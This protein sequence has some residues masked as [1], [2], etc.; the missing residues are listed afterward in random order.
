VKPAKTS[1]EL[2]A[3]AVAHQRA[4]RAREAESAYRQLISRNPQHQQAL[5][6]LSVLFLQSGR[7]EEASRYLERLV[8]MA[9][10]QPVLLTNLGEA[11]RR[12]GELELAAT[13]FERILE[14]DP[15]FPEARQNLGITLMDAGR[16]NEALPHLE[17]AVALRPDSALFHVSLAW[18][19]GKLERPDESLEHA[20]HA[21]ELEPEHASGHLHLAN[22]Q[23]D[24]GDRAGAIASYRRAVEL[25]PSD[26]RAHSNLILVALADPAW[27]SA[28][29]HAE[30][31]AWAKLHAEPLRVRIE[32]HTNDRRAD[33]RLRVGYVSPDFRAHPVRQFLM[34]LLRHHEPSAVEVFLYSSVERPDFSTEE[35]RTL[36][37][38]RFR[39]ISRTDDLA[40][41]ALV[42]RDRIDV[43]L[44]LAVHGAGHRLRVFAM[45]PAPVQM[46]WLGYNGTTGLDTVDYRI[47]DPY[48]DPPGTDPSDFS[49]AP[50]V[51]PE[52]YWCYDALE[53]D[54]PVAPL[55]ALTDGH[56]TFGC[57]NSYRKV[58]PG[59]LALWSRVLAEAPGSR[60]ALLVADHPR[61]RKELES[62]G[63]DPSRVDFGGRS[64]RREY[65]E[66]HHHVD[67]ALDTFP[68]CGGTTS[69]DAVFMGVPVVTLTGRTTLQRAGSSI[70]NNLGLPELVTTTE[71][72]FVAKAVEWARDVPR[73]S[74]L[75][76]SLRGR[77]E[78]S[79]FCDYPRFARNLESAY[80]KAWQTWCDQG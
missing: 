46:T 21:V 6:H 38:E 44:D 43:L 50:L 69:L 48:F 51:L 20:R 76:A 56:V 45:K 25:D 77:L 49:E 73:L 3:R 68:F 75:R 66:R 26:Y 16:P 61:V 47:T 28:M 2:L 52:S 78:A 14:L 7:F 19:L 57:L 1:T 5:F 8:E 79:P 37:G 55:P 12:G 23:N 74:A 60:L 62:A 72:A 34:P 65:L 18:A 33:R 67:L 32:P 10:D 36:A 27:D 71:D 80:R 39:D 22:A 58:H 24:L 42:R 15:D 17:R 9:P 13:T 35:Y 11:Y 30:A 41:A 54:L 64:S 70:A 29:L 4:G 63:I 40:V 59:A 53:Q 31:R